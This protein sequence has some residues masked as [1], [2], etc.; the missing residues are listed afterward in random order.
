LVFPLNVRI[1]FVCFNPLLARIPDPSHQLHAFPECIDDATGCD[2]PNFEIG[3]GMFGAF[4]QHMFEIGLVF[5]IQFTE[6][7]ILQLPRWNL[8]D[9]KITEEMS[10]LP[11]RIWLPTRTTNG[12]ASAN[13]TAWELACSIKKAVRGQPG[14]HKN[15]IVPL[16]PNLSAGE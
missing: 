14:R 12:P 10:S 6:E 3:S 7:E 1:L 13:V 16:E 15:V 8:F 11:S 4:A 9:R 2:R 5:N